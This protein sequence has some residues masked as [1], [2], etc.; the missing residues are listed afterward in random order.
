MANFMA[1]SRQCYLRLKQGPISILSKS[2]KYNTNKV[3]LCSSGFV[4]ILKEA[5]ASLE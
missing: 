5:A 3:E 1:A 2:N 4:C